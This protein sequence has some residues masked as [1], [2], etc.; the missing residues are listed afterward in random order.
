MSD[1]EEHIF[2]PFIS[3]DGKDSQGV[4]AEVRVFTGY[5]LVSDR[6]KPKNRE[7]SVVQFSFMAPDSQY[8]T[9]GWV[10]KKRD[11]E[12]FELLNHA[13]DEELAVDFRI[14]SQR[15]K[16]V[17]RSLPYAEIAP[18]KDNEK[19]FKN[20]F[21]Y[22]AAARA[23]E[24]SEWIVGSAMVT[25]FSADPSGDGTY[26]ASDDDNADNDGTGASID[27]ELVEL[28]EQVAENSPYVAVSGDGSVNMNSYAPTNAVRA[29][30]AVKRFVYDMPEGSFSSDEVKE[31]TEMFVKVTANVQK[32]ITREAPDM[33]AQSFS[34]SLDIVEGVMTYYV[35]L[36]PFADDF[37]TEKVEYFKK[38]NFIAKK[39]AKNNVELI[40]LVHG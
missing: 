21:R 7:S 16:N 30:L 19:A 15:K 6:K 40:D 14:E 8:P 5:A 1:R 11:P 29:T 32:F 36:T 13:Y 33:A 38:V 39:V 22:I 31:L 10:D 2:T 23:D 18:H 3:Y 26:K 27:P 35:P 20:T 37:E 34:T 9:S 25:S 28:V 4:R 24:D 12:L 17:D